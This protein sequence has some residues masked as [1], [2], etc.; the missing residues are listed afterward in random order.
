[1]TKT[2]EVSNQPPPLAGYD[3]AD[4]PALL[5]ALRRE[6]AEWAEASVRDLGRL[7]GSLEAQE[8][9]RLANRVPATAAYPRP[10]RLPD[11]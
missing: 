11:R 9:G 7:A 1:M 4:D 3:A 5:A 10:V 2:H 8:W 6:G